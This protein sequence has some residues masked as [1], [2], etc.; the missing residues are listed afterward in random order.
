MTQRIGR[1]KPV[2][3][4]RRARHD[5]EI[6]ESFE[7]GIVLI[8]LPI[9]G[10]PETNTPNGTRNRRT[11]GRGRPCILLGFVQRT[12]QHLPIT[13]RRF[14]ICRSNDFCTGRGLRTRSQP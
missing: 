2:T 13:P 4:N 3:T 11:A 9:A 1:T 12:R 14:P 8:R 7:A 10:N 5:Y 6:L